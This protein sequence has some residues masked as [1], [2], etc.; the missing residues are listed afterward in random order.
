VVDRGLS[1]PHRP[2]FYLQSHAAI[3][4]STSHYLL[5]YYYQCVLNVSSVLQ[6][7]AVA[8][9]LYSKTKISAIISESAF[10][11]HLFFFEYFLTA[12]SGCKSFRSRCATSIP[13][14]RARSPSPRPSTVSLI[15]FA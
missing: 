9:T 10:L 7:R 8:T 5:Y 1:N 4:G 14:R 2:D 13:R 12:R 15:A 6:P 11:F 3:K